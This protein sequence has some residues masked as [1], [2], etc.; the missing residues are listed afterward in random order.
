LGK[1]L[2]IRSKYQKEIGGNRGK[3]REIGARKDRSAGNWV[4]RANGQ[5]MGADEKELGAN[6]R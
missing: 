3:N 5:N 1:K 6:N 2:E 4:K